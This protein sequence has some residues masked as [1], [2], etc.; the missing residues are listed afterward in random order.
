M[1]L[2]V[3]GTAFARVVDRSSTA[4]LMRRR[5]HGPRGSDTA[6]TVMALPW[7]VVVSLA[8]T[9]L[10]MILP[11]LV[12]ISTAFIVG[13]AQAGTAGPPVPAR[14]GPLAIGMVAL[15]LAAW[16][17]PGGGSVRRGTRVSVATVARGPRSR[18]A[19]WAVIGLLFLAAVLTL[20]NGGDPD[21]GPLKGSRLLTQLN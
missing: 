12:G 6:V 2:V 20:G 9:L 5:V 14:P 1:W 4:L 7:R 13:T 17:G 11:V 15:L 8:V 10:A 18:I 16:W 21:F 19:V 3:Y